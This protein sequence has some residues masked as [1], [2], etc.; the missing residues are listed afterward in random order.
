MIFSFKEFSLLEKLNLNRPGNFRLDK[1]SL[2]IF[3]A[4]LPM[5]LELATGKLPERLRFRDSV[6]GNGARI[7]KFLK[8]F[9]AFEID[10]RKFSKR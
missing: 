4:K 1:A 3:F 6:G 2:F 8:G 10:R 9:L 7:L 5:I